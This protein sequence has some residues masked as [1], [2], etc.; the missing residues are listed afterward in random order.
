MTA[1]EFKEMIEIA[2]GDKVTLEVMPESY[3]YKR[4][5]WVRWTH[6]LIHSLEPH[7][8]ITQSIINTSIS[9]ITLEDM[10]EF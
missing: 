3:I 5:G 1:Q 2:L 9:F 4:K 6:G 7:A 10:K 8:F